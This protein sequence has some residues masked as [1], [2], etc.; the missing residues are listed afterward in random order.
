MRLVH[1]LFENHIDFYENQIN[2]LAIENRKFMAELIQEIN[3]QINGI[4]GRFVLSDNERELKLD[5]SCE[6]IVDYFNID[7]NNRKNLTQLYKVMNKISI[8]EDMYDET[9]EM[10]SQLLRFLYDIEDHVE[11]SISIDEEFDM[12]SVFKAI[13]IKFDIE[14]L[15]FVEKLIE[16]LMLSRNLCG[17]RVFVL[18]NLK[19]FISYDDLRTF[20]KSIFYCK[21]NVLL[22]ENADS[23]NKIECE[24]VTIIDQDLCEI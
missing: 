6:L 1:S 9:I 21:L 7:F 23:D 15:N 10:K 8:D 18:V 24:K 22:I 5:K 16:Y 13:D 20:Y 14:E 11:Y 3:N 12:I 19:S 4:S 2:V 17:T